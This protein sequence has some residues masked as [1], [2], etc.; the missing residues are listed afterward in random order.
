MQTGWFVWV[1][2]A[3]ARIDSLCLSPRYNISA[4]LSTV[5]VAWKT[6]MWMWM[7]ELIFS[8]FLSLEYWLARKAVLTARFPSGQILKLQRERYLHSLPWFQ[9]LL[10]RH[11][12]TYTCTLILLASIYVNT[13]TAHSSPNNNYFKRDTKIN[14]V[15]ALLRNVRCFVRRILYCTDHIIHFYFVWFF[16][17]VI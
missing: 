15:A 10:R 2:S 8:P 4:Y 6:T 16:H 5:A 1:R 11:Y 7:S 12:H 14:R 13:I 17:G 3:Q 9:R